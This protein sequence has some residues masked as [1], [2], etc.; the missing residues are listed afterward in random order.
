MADP[1]RVTVRRGETIES[2]H[3]VHAVAVQDGRVVAEAGDP[4]LVTFMRSAAKPIQA[5][6]LARTREDLDDR[7]LAIA[8]AS[9]LADDHQLVAVTALLAK[10]PATEDDLECGPFDGSKLRHNCSGKHA[11]MLALCHANDWPYAGYR[12]P[13][14]PCQQAM[15]AE[16]EA[17]A[18]TDEIPTATD[19][20]GVVT[21]ALSL[22]RIAT[23]FAGVDSRVADA[24][25]AHPELI[26]GPKAPDTLFMQT[27]EGW[28]AKGGAEGLICAASSDGLALALKVEDGH[29]RA[30]RP[31]LG[32]FLDLV[33]LDG[34]VF[35]P[36]ALR[37]SRDEL[38]GEVTIG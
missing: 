19:G 24:M 1:I 21:F 6:P 36:T 20:C 27:F 22:A 38:V 12:S 29:P 31:A 33:G 9:H 5:M 10:A 26:R 2:V 4:G 18:E 14:H 35:G 34:S 8:S 17:L 28:Y 7:D 25:R 11:G 16:V 23:A 32:A 15:R 3:H 37:N 30:L 13:D